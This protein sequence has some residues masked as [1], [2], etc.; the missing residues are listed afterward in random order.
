MQHPGLTWVAGGFSLVHSFLGLLDPSTAVEPSTF[1][2]YITWFKLFSQSS[3]GVDFSAV[4]QKF[5]SQ[6]GFTELSTML[7]ICT[8]YF[9]PFLFTFAYGH[10]CT[11]LVPHH[12]RDNFW[13]IS[14]ETWIFLCYEHNSFDGSMTWKQPMLLGPIKLYWSQFHNVWRMQIVS[15]ATYSHSMG[16]SQFLNQQNIQ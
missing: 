11:M 3:S 8:A 2:Y 9:V 15:F 4:V 13:C 6:F 7:K 16:Y 12:A 5:H 1:I 10:I 14:C